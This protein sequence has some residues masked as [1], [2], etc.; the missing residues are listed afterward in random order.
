M[1]REKRRVQRRPKRRRVWSGD[2][3]SDILKIA[4][5]LGYKLGQDKRYKRMGV[6]GGTGSYNRRRAPWEV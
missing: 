4:A 2:G 6:L 1:T 5:K 3:L